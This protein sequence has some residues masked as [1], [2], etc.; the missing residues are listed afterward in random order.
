MAFNLILSFSLLRTMPALLRYYSWFM[1][2]GL[3]IAGY[4]GYG[5]TACKAYGLVPAPHLS[6]SAMTVVG[7]CFVGSTLGSCLPWCPPQAVPALMGAA[8]VLY[9]LYFTQL[10]CEAHLGAHVTV[11]LPPSFLLLALSP[12]FASEGDPDSLTHAQ[13][14][15]FTVWM[16]KLII[17]FSYMGA[18]ISKIVS[19][20]K[21]RRCWWDGAALQ[22]C[23]L[24]ALYL[25]KPGTH[26]SFGL[27]TPFAH[28]IQR[29]CFLR[30]RS[31][32]A[33]LSFLGVAAEALAPL[34]LLLPASATSVLVP[35]I[36]VGFHVGVLYLQNVDFVSWWGPVY[37]F[38]FL[39]P[40]AASTAALV[41]PEQFGLL[42]CIHAAWELA[43]VRVALVIAYVVTHI[44]A[45]GALR[46]FPNVEALPFS[47]FPMFSDFK[48]L[49]DPSARKWIW[50]TDKPH[51][52]GTLK[53]YCFP[54]SR[55]P[56]V[57]VEELDKL[58]F[59]YLLFGHGGL[60]DSATTALVATKAGNSLQ[61][62]LLGSDSNVV[63]GTLGGAAD[64]V[65]HGNVKLTPEMVNIMEAIR[66]EGFRGKGAFAKDA[67][68][69]PRLLHL[70][71]EG[72]H[73]F[74][75]LERR[76]P[77]I[78]DKEE[79]DVLGYLSATFLGA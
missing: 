50:F 34:A 26:T 62:P 9:H 53:N 32:C 5:Q 20:V 60:T 40:A 67:D 66:V 75:K 47:R 44:V 49:F 14:A 11:L 12:C 17:V 10:Y 23:I 36:G 46:W 76:R 58:P 61:T 29:W 15:A 21:H 51:A 69:A 13:G 31:V 42:R 55:P 63:A 22:G 33:P 35:V 74:Q 1:S 30:P 2:S 16:M 57:T 45:V 18:G 77:K 3:E 27:P 43:P 73:A 72:Q 52:T 28:N 54:F 8:L 19:S 56:V 37:A 41:F 68:T 7:L 38:F 78:Y 59:R 48:D 71:L 39:D 65:V 70:L 25:C 64:V 6:T 79:G 24:E 4:R